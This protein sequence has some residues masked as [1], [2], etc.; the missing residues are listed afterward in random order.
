MTAPAMPRRPVTALH[1]PVKWQGLFQEAAY[2]D[3][4]PYAETVDEDDE[5]DTET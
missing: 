3:G 5:P 4:Q 1:P 2:E